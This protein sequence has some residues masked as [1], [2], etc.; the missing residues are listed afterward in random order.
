MR[1]DGYGAKSVGFAPISAVVIVC[2]ESHF[3]LP[4]NLVAHVGLA[5]DAPLIEF[6]NVTKRFGEKTILDKVNLKIYEN[7][8]TTII[9]KSGGGKSVL[10]KHIIGLITPDEGAIL[11]HG[12]PV[13][14]MKKSE[15]ENYRSRVAYLFRN[16]ALLDSMTVFDNV[17]FP[18]DRRR[19]SARKRSRIG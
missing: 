9:G 17:A 1:T 13:A 5:M 11:F 16:N 18:S 8:I 4:F 3:G 15:R 12:K 19:I 10:L 7:Q 2:N 14:A 6:R